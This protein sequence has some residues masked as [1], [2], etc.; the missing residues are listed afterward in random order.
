MTVHEQDA[1]D[2]DCI[3]EILNNKILPMYY[4][5]HD[6]WRQ[7]IQ[8]GM[9]DVRTQFDSNRMAREYYELLYKG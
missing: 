8:N 9:K 6:Q 4:D 1:Y 5:N 3:Y 2:L 7:L